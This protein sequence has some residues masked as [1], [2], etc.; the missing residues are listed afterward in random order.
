MFKHGA[1]HIGIAALGLGTL[2]LMAGCPHTPQP[3]EV[4]TVM[5]PGNEP[6]ELVW[7]P[8]G[9]FLMGRYTGE[10]DSEDAEDPQRPVELSGFWM[11]RYEIT[12]AQW[13]AVMGRN[14]SNF[15]GT[16]HP[17]ESV[18]WD[19][20][21]D[22]IETLSTYTN[23]SFRLPS[24]AEWEYACRAGMTA[25]FYWGDDLDYTQIGNHAW[26]AGNANWQT[27]DFG[28]KLPNAWGL[29]D[30]SGNVL[31]WCEDDWHE[32]Y[33]GAPADGTAWVDSPRPEIRVAR[34]GSWNGVGSAC[35]SAYR[36]HGYSYH[37]YT[38]FGFRLAE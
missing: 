3:G 32:S 5:L 36:Y 10:Q 30:M 17:V 34:G 6:L 13:L 19:D 38:Y 11:G 4:R 25:R 12:Q 27:Q 14:P 22:F 8:A 7:V 21:Q 28:Q 24:E 16:E 26:Y 29:Y 37:T 15:G 35:R 9:T 2:L 23:M 18:S 33:A 1:A 31:E 20:A